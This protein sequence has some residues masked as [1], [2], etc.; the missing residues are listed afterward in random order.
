MQLIEIKII[1][2]NTDKDKLFYLCVRCDN[3]QQI[4]GGTCQFHFKMDRENQGSS[5]LQ[6]GCN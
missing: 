1:K 3:V 4:F 5:L 2:Y 6:D